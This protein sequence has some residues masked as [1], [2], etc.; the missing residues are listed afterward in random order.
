MLE[1][2]NELLMASDPQKR[3]RGK[4]VRHAERDQAIAATL[5]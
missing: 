3:S 2:V 5:Q 4:V 1:D